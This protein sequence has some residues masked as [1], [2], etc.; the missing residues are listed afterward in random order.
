MEKIIREENVLFVWRQLMLLKNDSRGNNCSRG[1]Y[2][3]YVE[4]IDDMEKL[5]T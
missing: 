2:I 3:I 4:E 1:K 5:F